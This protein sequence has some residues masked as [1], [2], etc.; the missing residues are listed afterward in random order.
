MVRAA[1]CAIRLFY[2]TDTWGA[3][4]CFFLRGLAWRDGRAAFCIV[5]PSAVRNIG[6]DV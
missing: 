3:L 2:H 1:R 6:V 4:C 5:S